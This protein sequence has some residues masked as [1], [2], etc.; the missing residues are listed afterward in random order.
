MRDQ[1]QYSV[2]KAIHDPAKLSQLKWYLIIFG[3]DAL[4]FLLDNLSSSN[5]PFFEYYIFPIALS[6][7]L[8]SRKV[9]YL[10]IGFSSCAGEYVLSD[11]FSGNTPTIIAI[12]SFQIFVAFF[13]V[14][15][16]VRYVH[17]LKVIDIPSVSHVDN[18]AKLISE[19]RTLAS[20]NVVWQPLTVT[21]K[22]YEVMNGHRGAIV[23]LTGMPGSGKS[24]VA[25][26]VEEKLQLIKFK[27]VALDGDNIR[28]GLSAD[29]GFS[30][31]DRNEN[32]R[33]VGELAK[34]YLEQGMVVLVALVSPIRNAREKIK[35]SL[36]SDDFIEVYCRCPVSVCE[37]RDPKGMYAQ[38]RAGQIS[39][40]TGIS[41][42]YQEPLDPDLV[43]N[44]S[45]ESINESAD[46]L[47][48]LLTNKL[49]K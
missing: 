19:R 13:L 9:S 18:E 20:E 27:T 22:Q 41:S 2:P 49:R 32:V 21:R 33:R 5:I 45:N 30:E 29:L 16:L 15:F 44:T 4:I 37:E 40:F 24:T 26:A 31:E 46:R 25:H 17:R 42:P 7:W 39:N 11:A 28:H 47:V 1:I 38:A 36:A 48:Q 34:L 12:N 35:H 10:L 14:D 43:L 3:L 23:W 8:L 6:S